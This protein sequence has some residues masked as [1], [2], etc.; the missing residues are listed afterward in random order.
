MYEVLSTKTLQELQNAALRT[1]HRLSNVSI[2]FFQN[3]WGNIFFIYF[4]VVTAVT[5]LTVVKKITQPLH[6][7]KSHNLSFF[8][9][10]TF[11][12]FFSTFGKGNLTHLTTNVI[13]SGHRFA[14]LT[15][16][17][18]RGC[19]ILWVERLQDFYVWRGCMIFLTHSLTQ[20]AWFIFL[21]VA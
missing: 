12:Y 17:L 16:F 11:I 7:K 9:L 1:S 4:S 8:F 14:I 18:L 3:Y 5:V 2:A 20:V 10:S 21:E 13:L 19:M 15:M 6:A